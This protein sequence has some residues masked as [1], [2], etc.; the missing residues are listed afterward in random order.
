MSRPIITNIDFNNWPDQTKDY[1]LVLL[2]LPASILPIIL[3]LCLP[4]CCLI[5]KARKAESSSD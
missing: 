2:T 1:N 5:S 3:F 4:I